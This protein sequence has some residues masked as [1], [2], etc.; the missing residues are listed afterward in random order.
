MQT[1]EKEFSLTIRNLAACAE[2]LLG[3]CHR[4]DQD[5]TPYERIFGI[6]ELRLIRS[7]LSKPVLS[8]FIEELAKSLKM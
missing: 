8:K 6:P 2:H 3:Q 5:I 4:F 1:T 7:V